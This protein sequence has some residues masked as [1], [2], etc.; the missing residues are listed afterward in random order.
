MNDATAMAKQVESNPKQREI[1]GGIGRKLY[2]LLIKGSLLIFNPQ[3]CASTRIYRL[4]SLVSLMCHGRDVEEEKERIKEK[5]AGPRKPKGKED[6][7]K[8]NFFKNTFK[9]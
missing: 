7:L 6:Q 9:I 8:F 3:L 2:Q 1:N 4:L 5:R